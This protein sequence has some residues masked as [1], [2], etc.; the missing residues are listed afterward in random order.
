MLPFLK[1]LWLKR[2]FTGK[3]NFS[4]LV[5]EIYAY[6]ENGL[7]EHGDRLLWLGD[8]AMFNLELFACME[9]PETTYLLSDNEKAALLESLEKEVMAWLS[10]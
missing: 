3:T 2:Y 8:E 7:W 6:N 5:E 4:Q 1:A 10:H 9:E